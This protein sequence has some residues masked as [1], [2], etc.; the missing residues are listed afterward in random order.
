[1]SGFTENERKGLL[2]KVITY[3]DTSTMNTY[4]S[5]I[6]GE[7]A[8]SDIKTEL[9]KYFTIPELAILLKKILE[10]QEN[11]I[12]TM[13]RINRIY[14]TNYITNSGY[15]TIFEY[16]NFWR[17][18]YWNGGNMENFLCGLIGNIRTRKRSVIDKVAKTIKTKYPYDAFL[19]INEY[20]D[21]ADKFKR[22]G[23]T[24]KHKRFIS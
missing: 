8:A 11:D 19:Y 7:Y 1:M 14:F 16:L 24:R 2:G 4:Q 13:F 3:L 9:F 18:K 21:S 15:N 10:C 17:H 6:Y 22:G 23:H 5:S 12:L 20:L